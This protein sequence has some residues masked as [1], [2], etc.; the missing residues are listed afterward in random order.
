MIRIGTR[1]S[2]DWLDRPDDLSFIKQIGVDYVDIVNNMI[3][4]Y[5][6]AG[7]RMSR[8]GLQEVVDNLEAAGLKIERANSH[9]QHFWKTWHGEPGFEKEI[10]NG[11]ENARL[12]GEFGIPVLGVQPYTGA[13]DQRVYEGHNTRPEGRGGYRYSRMDLSKSANMP[14]NPDAPDRDA[15]WE[16]TINLYEQVVPVAQEAGVNVATHGND[17]PVPTLFGN[18]QIIIDFASFDRLF[19]EVSNPNNGITFCVGTRYESGENVFEGIRHFGGQNRLFHV[20]FRNVKGT[21]PADG[22]YSEVAPDEGDLDMFKVAKALHD[23]G[24]DGVIDYDHIM[25][26]STDGPA[27]REYIAYVVGHMR[28][29]LQSLESVYGG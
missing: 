13:P 12:C 29:I 25:R 3:P 9:S 8:E 26:L 1:I 21:I 28:G 14:L 16:R 27:G 18:P 15:L 20:H 17:P 6:E 4:G 24:Y 11:Q 19:S 22:A 7:G 5:E 10:E 23:V 2:P